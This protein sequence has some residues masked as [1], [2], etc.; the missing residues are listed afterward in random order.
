MVRRKASGKLKF[1][2]AGIGMCVTGRASNIAAAG[3]LA[4][5]GGRPASG[6]ALVIPVAAVIVWAANTIVSKSAAGVVDPMAMTFY[7]WVIAAAALTP[8]CVRSLWRRR[9]DVRPHLVRMAILAFFGMVLNQSL[10]Y[11]G[12]HATT[13]MDMGLIF[14]LIPTLTLLLNSALFAEKAAPLAIAGVVVSFV[15]VVVVIVAGHPQRLLF[16][17]AVQ[18]DLLILAASAAYALYTVLMRRWTPAAFGPWL[19]LYI[20]VLLASAM[21]APMMVLASSMAIPLRGIGLVLFASIGASVVGG[22]LWILGIRLLGSART[23]ITMNLMPVFTALMAN[24]I[25]GEPVRGNHWI[26]GA[27]ILLGVLL[28]QQV[29]VKSK[30]NQKPHAI[31]AR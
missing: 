10:T 20:Q 3:P 23:A 30:I 18:G 19:T 2:L 8:F 28:A 27:L 16:S 14:A 22:Y 13:A 4:L 31:G 21:L 12:A 9:A 25:I 5:A 7:R 29:A 17:S 1:L 26:G 15:G 11:V 24:T 6:I